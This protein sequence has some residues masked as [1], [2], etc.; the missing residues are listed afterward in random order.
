MR[1]ICVF[2]AACVLLIPVTASAAPKKKASDST[3]VVVAVVG[4]KGT[5]DLGETAKVVSGDAIAAAQKKA[6]KK[7]WD[8]D[9][10][11]ALLAKNDVDVLVRAEKSGDHLTLT[12]FGRDG[13]KRW[14]K[15]V[16]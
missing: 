9:T 11:A 15:D 13:D 8:P 5:M 14:Q 16:A 1:H 10:I 7:A 2:V 4:A 12:G 3:G 6:G